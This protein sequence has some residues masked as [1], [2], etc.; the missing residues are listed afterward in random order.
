MLCFILY[1]GVSYRY[2]IYRIQYFM[3]TYHF[4]YPDWTKMKLNMSMMRAYLER[5]VTESSIQ[6]D[7]R[8]IGGMRFIT[9]QQSTYSR[10][11][12]Y[13]GA[14]NDF[15]ED[16]RYE[17]ALILASGR[18]HIVCEGLDR[19]EL[20]NA[21]LSSFDFYND[22]EHQ[23]AMM[24][25]RHASL[26]EMTAIAEQ[27]IEAP[28]LVF[29]IDGTYLGGSHFESLPDVELAQSIQDQGSL[30]ASI[31]GSSFVDDAGVVH[32][33]LSNKPKKT[34]GPAG[35]AAVNMYLHS[36]GETVGFV[37][38]FP[39]RNE[40]TLLAFGLEPFLEEFLVCA[41]E[42]ID[43]T[44]PHQSLHL[45]LYDHLHG[46]VVSAEALAR[47]EQAMGD[48][49]N[50]NVV[51]VRS[52]AI[53]NPT[54]RTLLVREIGNLPLSCVATEIGETVAFLVSEHKTDELIS[55]VTERF[56]PSNVA[57][58]VSM[59][60]TEMSQAPV[61][62]RQAEFACNDSHEPGVRYCKDL[63]L[64]FLLRTLQHEPSTQ[65]LLHPAINILATYD[66][67]H[68]ASL[69]ETLKAYLDSGFNQVETAKQLHVHLN[70]VKY[71][72]KRIGEL[73]PI[74]YGHKTDL[75]Y[76]KLSFELLH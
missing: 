5:C 51:L 31:I 21:V 52:L 64:S 71:R 37:M 47:L 33:D 19:E 42:F 45:A 68:D 63:A 35:H 58:G 75:F 61:G 36:N 4:F 13:I 60:L 69:L 70:T 25:A 7:T 10:D 9:E 72:L 26:A 8:T 46:N 24:A 55:R 11:Y 48:Y 15:F 76:L 67:G 29:S 20:L 39:L 14:A 50:L 43:S 3:N 53:N 74:D 54:Q 56:E 66:E 16:P 38:C 59:P 57:L 44:S 1:S 73:A 18:N 49:Q 62:F 12:I 34:Y 65:D 17:K 28:F 41:R 22:I 27:L 23:L 40:H 2:Y 30:G 32:H 6:S